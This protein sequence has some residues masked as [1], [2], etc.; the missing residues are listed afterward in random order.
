M[1]R[2]NSNSTGF[3][4][5]QNSIC[6]ILEFGPGENNTSTGELI[7]LDGDRSNFTT[8]SDLPPLKL[9]WTSPGTIEYQIPHVFMKDDKTRSEVF[10][11]LF[12]NRPYTHDTAASPYIGPYLDA[13]ELQW[14]DK[15][16]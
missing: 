16:A 4:F 13:H 11:C 1:V 5:P 15:L 6:K 12:E 10:F 9:S 14:S 8:L 7:R 2:I 3:T